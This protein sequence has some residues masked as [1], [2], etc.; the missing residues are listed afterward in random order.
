M[1]QRDDSGPMTAPAGDDDQAHA[2][3]NDAADCGADSAMH[4]ECGTGNLVQGEK[5]DELSA[6]HISGS[7]GSP[8]GKLDLL[9][10]IF[11]TGDAPARV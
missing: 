1:D 4:G 9:I 8:S 6:F 7:S 3:G 2:E 10:I 5:E 11:L